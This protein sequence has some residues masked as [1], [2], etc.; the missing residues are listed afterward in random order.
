M[1]DWLF[2]RFRCFARCC[3][4]RASA[5]SIAVCALGVVVFFTPAVNAASFPDVP[6]HHPNAAAIDYLTTEGV[7]GGYPDGTFRPDQP[8]NRAEALKIILLGSGI[9]MLQTSVGEFPDVPGE[10]WFA[11]FVATARMRDIV[12]GY[13]DGS[14]RPE[15]TVNLVESLKI[16]LAAN[17]I[18]LKNYETDQQLFADS[19]VA[20]WYNSFL[21]YAREFELVEITNNRVEPAAPLTRGKLAEVMYRFTNRVDRVCPQ[22]YGNTKHI[23]ADYFDGV[24]LSTELPNIFFEDEVFV[25]AGTIAGTASEATI[26]YFNEADEQSSFSGPV[27]SGNFSIPISFESPGSYELFIIPGTKGRGFVATIDIIPRECVP[28]TVDLASNPAASVTS[29]I[30]DNRPTIHWTTAT[31]NIARI[32]IRSGDRRYERLVTAGAT[33]LVLQP[34]D[35]ANWEI[36]TATVQVFLAHSEHG[37]SYEPRTSWAAS[38]VMSLQLA[39]HEYAEYRDDVITLDNTPSTHTNQ[40]LHFAVTAGVPLNQAAFLIRPDGLVEE[41]DLP[42]V[43]DP[44][45]AGS[46]FQLSLDLPITGTYILEINDTDNL[47]ALNYPI[48]ADQV[49]PVIPDFVDLSSRHLTPLKKLSVNRERSI[50]LRLVNAERLR[51]GLATVSLDSDLVNLAQA[52]AERMSREDFFGHVDLAGETP[53]DRRI[54]AGIPLPVGENLAK[55][56]A[57]EYA[58]AGL[59]RSAA[60]R[61]NLLNPAWTHVGLGVAKNNAGEMI[62]VQEFTSTRLT[63]DAVADTRAAL[64]D[65]LN[66]ARIAN[67]TS[68]F[69]LDNSL[70]HVAQDWSD[71]MVTQDFFAFTHG[72]DSIEQVI[73]AGGYTGSFS[74][75]IASADSLAHVVA[76]VRDDGNLLNIDKQQVAIGIAQAHTGLYRVTFIFR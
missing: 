31:E 29:T 20:A 58:H 70:T 37:W 76:S 17:T 61:A 47:A 23:K 2:D 28:A 3:D 39:Q 16:V 25:I 66:T 11:D 42:V 32:V 8:V 59:M 14:F 55:D 33:S 10:A 46:S 5:L 35:F 30:A 38:D 43:T 74:T 24:T 1:L 34:V 54:A 48:Y 9:S 15:Q 26:F 56:V 62:F 22:F 12:A 21:N 75:F 27:V 50:W 19:D 73:S 40:T 65:L 72:D 51:Y 69:T 60:H 49:L 63:A 18:A 7:I 4:F 64:L 53:D 44:I 68:S 41:F 45:P 71:R 67:Q 57:T 13:P 52:Y 6:A 36:G